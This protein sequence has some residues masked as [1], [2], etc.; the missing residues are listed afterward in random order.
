MARSSTSVAPG[1]ALAVAAALVTALV[2]TVAP[3]A[4]TAPRS[5]P[6]TPFK[7]MTFEAGGTTRVGLVLGA[8]VL[9]IA[10]ANRH[11]TTRAKLA[12]LAMP[13]DMKT[14][15]EQYPAVSPRLY[16]IA[17]YFA[18]QATANLPFAFDV[19]AVK[20]LAPIK[21]PWNLM[22]ASANYRAHAEGMGAAGAGQTA[23]PPPA[24]P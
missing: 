1:T 2:A 22:A 14:L 19:S 3:T 6:D 17:N 11:L 13:G 12:A 10:G 8:R 15:I 23:A 7:L 9:D 5:T 21:Y 18:A 16:Q 20:V 4:Q 24:A